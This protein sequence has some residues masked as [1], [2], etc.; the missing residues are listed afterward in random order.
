[1]EP[2]PPPHGA[3]NSWHSLA[4]MQKRARAHRVSS[5]CPRIVFSV[6]YLSVHLAEAS[7]CRGKS[8][9][10]AVF[11][12]SSSHGRVY[13]PAAFVER[14]RCCRRAAA[15][16]PSGSLQAGDALALAERGLGC[17]HLLP[18]KQTELPSRG[19]SPENLN[20]LSLRPSSLSLPA[21]SV[22]SDK[23]GKGKWFRPDHHRTSTPEA[24]IPC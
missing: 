13:S 12:E 22:A 15:Q 2:S 16:Q 20:A 4:G 19:S 17:I 21:L 3:G 5:L 6:D 9:T 11:A 14:S 8:S 18:V 10:G 23:R 7:H 1:M 24:W